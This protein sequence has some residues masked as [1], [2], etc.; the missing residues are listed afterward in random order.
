MRPLEAANYAK[1]GRP[2]V[3]LPFPAGGW[4]NEAEGA[5]G[6]VA[7]VVARAASGEAYQG[8]TPRE[9]L[10]DNLTRAVRDA[11]RVGDMVAARIAL[12]ALG[13]LIETLR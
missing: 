7:V 10:V 4:Q 13:E 8:A 5:R 1:P 6:A 3:S 9:A 11:F 2:D 12:R